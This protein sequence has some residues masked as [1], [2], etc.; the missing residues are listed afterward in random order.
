MGLL[1]QIR[2]RTSDI[3]IRDMFNHAVSR[4]AAERRS[5]SVSMLFQYFMSAHTAEVGKD[6]FERYFACLKFQHNEPFYR[7]QYKLLF[8]H[9]CMGVVH[10]IFSES[11]SYYLQNP[12]MV[13]PLF[14]KEMIQEVG[15]VVDDGY[16]PLFNG[17]LVICGDQGVGKSFMLNTLLPHELRKYVRQGATLL[18]RTDHIPHT[19]AAALKGA[20]L[21]NLED[22]NFRQIRDMHTYMKS[23]LERKSWTYR[24]L[25][26][27]D[28]KKV[29]R[30]FT[31]VASTNETQ[32][33]HD[34]TGNR[35]IFASVGYISLR[36]KE[37]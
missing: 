36:Q 5:N 18:P 9:F 14:S 10:N 35:R 13:S 34:G 4:L 32:I 20:V 33:I 31:P 28:I 17:L 15:A 30:R 8:H 37:N 27:N 19:Q 22:V 21:V 16:L 23:Q 1:R 11:L 26:D 7:E 2:P 3:E 29:I 24:Y 25:F 6:A 12:D